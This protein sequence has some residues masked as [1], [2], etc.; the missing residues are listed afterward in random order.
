MDPDVRMGE[1]W[2]PDVEL[3]KLKCER[4]Y[5]PDVTDEERARKILMSSAPMAAQS[6]A[7]LSVHAVNEQ[8]RLKA[9]TYIID[10]VVGGKLRREGDTDDVLYALVT[11]LAKN[12]AESLNL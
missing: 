1:Q 7:W 9:S 4:L 5:E 6:L 8:I 12:D 2:I 3:E 10:G 11:E